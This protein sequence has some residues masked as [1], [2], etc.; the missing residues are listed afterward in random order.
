MN[1][2]THERA[3]TIEQSVRELA[4]IGKVWAR[5][6]LQVGQSALEASAHTLRTTAGVL[7][8]LSDQF[9]AEAASKEVT[10]DAA[11]D[12]PEVEVVDP[13]SAQSAAADEAEPTPA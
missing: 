10:D 7:G 2:R 3:E 4:G 5:H 1:E 6:G 8:R 13:D 9:G 12:A 11:T